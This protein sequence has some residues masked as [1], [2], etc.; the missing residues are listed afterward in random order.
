MPE[1]ACEGGIPLF[2]WTRFPPPQAYL[3][4]QYLGEYRKVV[5]GVVLDCVRFAEKPM[6]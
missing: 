6:Q 2:R 5:S 4:S 1:E 3:L